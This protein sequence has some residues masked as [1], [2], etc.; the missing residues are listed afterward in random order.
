[1]YEEIQPLHERQYEI[2]EEF[3]RVC[4][5]NNLTYYLAFGTLL[6]AVRHQG[7]IPWDDDI[8]TGIPYSDYNRLESLY[9]EGKFKEGFFLQTAAT[10]PNSGTTYYKL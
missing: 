7:F 6:G 8:D 1:M 2:L 9:K 4:D 5:E 10:D 3:K